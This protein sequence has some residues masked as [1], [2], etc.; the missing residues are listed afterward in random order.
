MV[1]DIPVADLFGLV[2]HDG[3]EIAFPALPDPM[4]RRGRHAGRVIPGDQIDG[5]R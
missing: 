3:S 1:L 5:S 2:G 4:A